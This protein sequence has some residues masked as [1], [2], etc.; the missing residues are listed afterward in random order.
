MSTFLAGKVVKSRNVC[1]IPLNTI[2][3]GN[4]NRK[5]IK[6]IQQNK[7]KSGMKVYP[8][9]IKLYFQKNKKTSHYIQYLIGNY[10]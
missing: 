2:Y 10:A 5:C 8:Q 1:K 3:K 7:Q 6:M 9:K 4:R